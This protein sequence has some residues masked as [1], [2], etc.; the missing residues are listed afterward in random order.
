[1]QQKMAAEFDQYDDPYHQ[2]Q[3]KVNN[4]TEEKLIDFTYK[5][6]T[7]LIVLIK[8]QLKFWR[9]ILHNSLTKSMAKHSQIPLFIL[10]DKS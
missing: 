4:D 10:N 1:M 3:H 2:F 9:E 5:N 8:H 7:D 6:K